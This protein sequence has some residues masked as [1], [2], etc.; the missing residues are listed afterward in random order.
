MVATADAAA[1][2]ELVTPLN[3]SGG[4]ATLYLAPAN[5]SMVADTLNMGTTWGGAW[6]PMGATD[7]GFHLSI[8]PTTVDWNIEESSLPAARIVDTMDFTVSASLKED[9]IANLRYAVGLG[10]IATQAAGVG[11][12]GKST[13][14][15]NTVMNQF[16]LGL[17]HV[18]YTGHWT[19]YYVPVVMGGG[20][21]AIDFRRS[22]TPRMY[23]LSLTA[24]CLPS[25]I[26]IVQKTAESTG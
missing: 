25:Q 26:Q 2:F 11:A 12:V 17:E 3:V 15:F 23:G 20:A 7:D 1:P 5:T 13:L 14:N 21:T 9:P 8:A 24:V 19:R 22:Q 10:T 16:A 4:A 18:N 6:V